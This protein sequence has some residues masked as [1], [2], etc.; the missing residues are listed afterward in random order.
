MSTPPSRPFRVA[1]RDDFTGPPLSQ[2]QQ[3]V[4]A[5]LVAGCPEEG[6][7][8]DAR[9]VAGRS[10][11]RLGATVV[12]LR[13]LANRR[14]AIWHDDE[15]EGWAPTMTGRSRV[16][17]YRALQVEAAKRRGAAE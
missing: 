9:T 13:S 6:S 5:A 2:A 11:L 14:L 8:I 1:Q 15:P 3:R 12:V 7:D 4:L 17:H 16:R 10:D